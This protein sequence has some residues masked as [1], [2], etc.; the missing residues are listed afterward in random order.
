MSGKFLSVVRRR[1]LRYSPGIGRNART[2]APPRAA[3]ILLF[4]NPDEAK[5]CIVA[6]EAEKILLF[7]IDMI[8]F[9]TRDAIRL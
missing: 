1:V 7:S 6:L 9:V 5:T 8:T 2:A 4:E 3:V